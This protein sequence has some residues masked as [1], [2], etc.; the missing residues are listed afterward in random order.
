M[1]S[2]VCTFCYPVVNRTEFATM[3]S[4]T[5]T[6]AVHDFLGEDDD[7]E[8]EKVYNTY[9]EK[10]NCNLMRRKIQEFLATKEMSQTKFLETIGDVNPLAVT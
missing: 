8:Q 3:T 10:W 6:H 1:Y 9:R 4:I 5:P 7:D 2:N